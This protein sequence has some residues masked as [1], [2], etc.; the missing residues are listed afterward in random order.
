VQSLSIEVLKL[1]NAS[2]ATLQAKN[3]KRS[4]LR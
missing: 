3:L 2:I 4:K 1:L